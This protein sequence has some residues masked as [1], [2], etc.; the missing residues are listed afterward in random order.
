ME[1]MEFSVNAKALVGLVDM[2]DRR[3][4]D[5]GRV[6]NYVN[7]QSALEWGPG[8]L[9]NNFRAAHKK[10]GEEVIAFLR[11]VRAHQPP[12]HPAAR[13]GPQQERRKNPPTP[14]CP[15][16]R[17]PAARGRAGPPP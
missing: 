13:G 12:P 17:Y 15:I 16:T 5:I 6:A 4:A 8:L 3:G 14:H 10:V 11:R 2:L 9:N 1:A 7:A